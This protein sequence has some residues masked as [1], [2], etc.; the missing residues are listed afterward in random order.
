MVSKL[1]VEVGDHTSFK[2]AY[3]RVVV[4]SVAMLGT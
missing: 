1:S 4:W 2:K 3:I